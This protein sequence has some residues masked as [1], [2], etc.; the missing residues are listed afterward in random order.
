MATTTIQP[1]NLAIFVDYWNFQ[2][3]CNTNNGNTN[4][5]IDWTQLNGWVSHH[6]ANVLSR[7]LN[8]ISHVSTYIYTSYNPLTAAEQKYKNWVNSFLSIQPG[9][10]V[11]CLERK[12]KGNQ[13]CS[14]CKTAVNFCPS[15]NVA[16]NNTEEKGVDTRLSVQMLDLAVNNA[17]DV[18]AIISHDAD[19]IPAVEFVQS[20]GKRVIHFGFSPTGFELRKS[21]THN[22]DMKTDIGR[23]KR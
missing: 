7:P 22:F 14:S 5:N 8:E 19:M 15:C 16:M 17:Y 4:F 21:C 12:K 9:F 11:T 18:A 3:S 2:L 13:K 10:K 6:V 20:R 1:L 23:I